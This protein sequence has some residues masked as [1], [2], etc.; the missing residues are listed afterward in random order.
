MISNIVVALLTSDLIRRV[1]VHTLRMTT[2]EDGVVLWSARD[3]AGELLESETLGLGDEQSGEA[4][5]QHE[6]GV[7]F[8]DVVEPWGGVGLGGA[9]STEGSER[10]LSDDGADL[11]GGGGDTVAGGAVAGWE[12]F[13]RDDEG[14]C[15]GSEVEE[16]LGDNVAGQKTFFSN[17][18]V[19]E[20]HDAENDCQDD[21]AHQLNW[22]ASDGVGESD[23]DPVA[24]NCSS[25][26]QD[27]VSNS[28]V[29]QVLV[30]GLATGIAN[31]SQNSSVV[32]TDTVEC[33][34]EEKPRTGS[35]EQDLAV[36]PLADV[37]E[38]VGPGCLGDLKLGSSVT[39]G[40]DA[41]DFI[42]Y[43]LGGASEVSLDIR[44]TLD[45]VPGDIEGVARSLGNGQTE[46]EGDGARNCTHSNDDTPHLVDGLEADAIARSDDSGGVLAVGG[47]ERLL[48]PNGDNQSDETGSK[49]TETLHGK[50]G[51]HHSASPLGGSE[52][53]GNDGRQWIVCGALA[54]LFEI[55][56]HSCKRTTTDTDSHEHTPED[57]GT[58]NRE[59]SGVRSESLCDSAKDD[60][61]QL[62]TVHLLATNDISEE[63]E[64][65]L[66]N[67]G[68]SRGSDLDG[69]VGRDGDLAGSV[70]FLPVNYPQHGGNDTNG[71]DVVGI[72]EET[73]TSDEDGA[74]VVPAEG[75]LIDLR[76][77]KSASLVGVG[78]VSIVVVEVVEGRVA[79]SSPGGHGRGCCLISEPRERQGRPSS[80][81]QVQG[82]TWYSLVKLAARVAFM[83]LTS[84][85]KDLLSRGT[86]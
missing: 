55:P 27:H 63:T 66:T 3:L 33:D 23:S 69:G 71:E 60:D 15:V 83:N 51:S 16:E 5:S 40:A 9:A 50:D 79:S 85:L 52:F 82:M 61:D 14:G 1:R 13:T 75:G 34:I 30:S 54:W 78:N 62:E 80:W 20:T 86:G 4:T 81:G 28:D 6:Q 72:G 38:E 19:S 36:L 73:D 21:E 29:V 26:D 46:V 32:E 56:S 76:E 42:W 59:S 70:G 12:A 8:E 65:K 24:R 74:N 44:T 58:S 77:R 49:L 57:D 39:H 41:S 7:D 22:L 64:S 2:S 45:D 31:G 48:E 18:V 37:S 35:S 10:S 53:R 25:A 68:A 17:L 67:D 84:E 11:A 47:Q 43:T